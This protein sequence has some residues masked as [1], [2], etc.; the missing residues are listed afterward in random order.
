MERTHQPKVTKTFICTL[1]L[2]LFLSRAKAFIEKG[3]MNRDFASLLFE[4][5]IYSFLFSIFWHNQ[6]DLDYDKLKE[7][8]VR[9]KKDDKKDKTYEKEN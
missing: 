1:L 9:L 4:M 6:V 5:I 3:G 8:I 7:L 2:G